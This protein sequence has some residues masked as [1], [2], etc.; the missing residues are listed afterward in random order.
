MPERG[1]ALRFEPVPL[2][3]LSLSAQFDAGIWPTLAGMTFTN[4]TG[5]KILQRTVNVRTSEDGWVFTLLNGTPLSDPAD[6]LREAATQVMD[7]LSKLRAVGRGPEAA[8]AA[9]V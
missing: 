5:P 1:A 2:R 9:D 7:A 4:S 8:G 3:L 6:P